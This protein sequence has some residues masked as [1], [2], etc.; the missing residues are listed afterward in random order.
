MINK[1]IFIRIIKSIQEQDKIDDDLGKAL[2]TVC[3]SYCMYGTKNKKYDALHILL[4]EVFNDKG[5]W[6]SWWLYEA[7]DKYVYIDSFRGKKKLSLKTVEQLY[8][9]LIQNMKRV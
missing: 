5:D 6:I 1:K 8:D 2:E 7:V 3:D 4:K 9:F